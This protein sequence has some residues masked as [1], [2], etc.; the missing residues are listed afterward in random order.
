MI[1]GERKLQSFSVAQ[2]YFQH[3]QSDHYLEI[4]MFIYSFNEKSRERLIVSNFHPT[5]DLSKTIRCHCTISNQDNLKASINFRFFR[6]P[7]YSLSEDLDNLLDPNINYIDSDMTYDLY[8]F[9]FVFY[10]RNIALLVY[11][12]GIAEFKHQQQDKRQ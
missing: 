9:F 1:I 11:Y 8:S 7:K 6:G 5:V 10:S 2:R 12:E 3:I 4:V